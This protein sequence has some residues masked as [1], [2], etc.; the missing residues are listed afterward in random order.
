MKKTIH[1]ILT[2]VVIVAI[3]VT[4]AACFGSEKPV[5]PT[6]YSQYTS[7]HSLT[8]DYTEE[9][10]EKS[11]ELQEA[12]EEENRQKIK[13]LLKSNMEL[14][15]PDMSIEDIDVLLP[16]TPLGL[17][18]DLGDIETVRQ[19]LKKGAITKYIPGTTPVINCV[20][21]EYNKGDLELIKLLIEHGASPAEPEVDYQKEFSPPIVSAAGLLPSWKKK[22][23]G[24]EEEVTEIFK[25]LESMGGNIYDVS[26]YGKTTLILAAQGN[27]LM[28]L[29]YLVEEKHM[30]INHQTISGWTALMAAAWF[31][32]TNERVKYLLEH[33]ADKTIVNNYGQT[34][35][36][37]AI[38]KGIQ[39]NIDLLSK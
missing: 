5:S 12:I 18:C 38:E 36:D 6:K 35:L 10:Y 19:L 9:D 22:T 29:K 7:E 37:V 4:A 3:F 2:A 24:A 27:N 33:G 25:L 16:Q 14:N 15:C 17:A 1:S 20:L 21:W 11:A 23:P 28:L 13:K 32:E 8:R 34:A 26:L 31:D 30:D 39:E